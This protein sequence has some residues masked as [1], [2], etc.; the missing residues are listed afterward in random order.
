MGN[1]ESYR[2]RH[3]HHCC[4]EDDNVV[5]PIEDEQNGESDKHLN[6]AKVQ[7]SGNSYVKVKVEVDGECVHVSE[8]GEQAEEKERCHKRKRCN[9]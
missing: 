4:E 5:S 6:I 8:S 1:R 2:F 7:N 3:D 9:K